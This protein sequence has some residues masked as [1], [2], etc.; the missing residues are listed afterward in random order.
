M[1]PLDRCRLL[2]QRR[3]ASS[4]RVHAQK[5]QLETATEWA[6]ES[7]TEFTEA[8]AWQ[9]EG[10][11]VLAATQRDEHQAALGRAAE[12][13]V[14]TPTTGAPNEVKFDFSLPE[15][16]CA[17]WRSKHNSAETLGRN[18]D[19]SQWRGCRLGPYGPAGALALRWHPRS[20]SSGP[21]QTPPAPAT[22]RPQPRPE[23]PSWMTR[24]WCHIA[25]R[26]KIVCAWLCAR[27]FTMCFPSF[28][29]S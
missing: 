23:R 14:T 21:R 22:Q 12:A 18:G 9:L 25:V 8:R 1:P 10:A 29:I 13:G 27:V 7:E 15:D 26:G 20:R 6:V 16:T 5:Q 17:G 3:Q 24:L 19:N 28:V 11:A 4:R 2:G